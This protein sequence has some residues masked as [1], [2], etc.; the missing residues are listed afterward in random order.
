MA[1]LLQPRSCH[2]LAIVTERASKHGGTIQVQQAMPWHEPKLAAALQAGAAD[3]RDLQEQ[4]IRPQHSL[5]L[6]DEKTSD[7]GHE[8]EQEA[9]WSGIAMMHRAIPD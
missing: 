3:P 4:A 6:I 8:N 5:D 9:E 7:A 2:R 1:E